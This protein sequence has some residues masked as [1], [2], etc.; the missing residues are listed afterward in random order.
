[1]H[2]IIL[3]DNYICFVSPA[4]SIS[5]VPLQGSMQIIYQDKTRQAPH[6]IQCYY[7]ATSGSANLHRSTKFGVVIITEIMRNEKVPIH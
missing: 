7:H 2:I 6:Q 5:E 4:V 1:M 3:D